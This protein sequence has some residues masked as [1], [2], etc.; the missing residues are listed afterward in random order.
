M[1]KQSAPI[2]LA[3]FGTCQGVWSWYIAGSQSGIV[4]YPTGALVAGS[5]ILVTITTT[6][7]S[8][9]PVSV[10]DDGGGTFVS[11]TGQPANQ[12]QWLATAVAAEVTASK[13]A[14]GNRV[15]IVFPNA[16][17]KGTSPLLT[18]AIFNPAG[19]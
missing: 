2:S 5:A 14:S 11:Q 17:Q 12:A 3:G 4:G 1:P 9:P 13:T 7:D 19:S 18:V 6:A 15:H 10:S 16:V 8:L